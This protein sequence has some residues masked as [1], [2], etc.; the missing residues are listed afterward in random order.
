MKAYYVY[1][2]RS[3]LDGKF[4]TGFTSDLENRLAEHNSGKVSSTKRRIPFEII[5]YEFSLSIDDAIHREKYLKSTYG[6]RYIRSRLKN[7][8][9]I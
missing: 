2:L 9:S 3:K 5:Y 6:K 8:L 7:Y 4:Y 1:V